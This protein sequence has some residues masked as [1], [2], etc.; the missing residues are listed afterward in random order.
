MRTVRCPGLPG[1]DHIARY[2][3]RPLHEEH[4]KPAQLV[5]AQRERRRHAEV[6][7]TAAFAGPE[8]VGVL[9]SVA[10]PHR[11]VG[12]DD[13]QRFDRVA[14]EAELAGQH[15]DAAAEREPGQA[16]RWARAAGNG[17][18]VG[19]EV[20][21]QVDQVEAGADRDRAVPDPEVADLADIDDKPAVEARPARVAVPT[22]SDAE[23]KLKLHDEGQAGA[24]VG[25]VAAVRDAR[26]VQEVKARIEKLVRERIGTVAG[27]AERAGRQLP[28]QR[29]PVRVGWTGVWAEGSGRGTRAWQASRGDG[30]GPER[31]ASQHEPAT[32]G[33]SICQP[34]HLSI[35]FSLSI[36]LFA[37]AGGP[38]RTLII[39][40]TRVFGPALMRSGQP[41]G[42]DLNLSA[43][44]IVTCEP[45]FA[46]RTMP[47]RA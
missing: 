1:A 9:R 18:A 6:A 5:R 11:A 30:A 7:A 27:T 41:L 38:A 37:Q 13:L 34:A 19:G 42:Q 43:A 25:G 17:Q 12:G 16:D 45:P 20:L 21:V 15:S 4:D 3:K 46:N 44:V 31:G 40:R 22:R 26:G 14:G 47:D 29:R 24:H 36:W 35:F 28:A 10:G 33:W 32:V 23:A 39:G 2:R 8:Q